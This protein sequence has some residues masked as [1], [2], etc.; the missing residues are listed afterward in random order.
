MEP[1]IEV[2]ALTKAFG[3]KQ[4]LRQ[5]DFTIQ[6][7]EIYGFLGPSGS[8]KTTTVKILSGQLL[9]TTGTARV[10][11]VDIAKMN[12]ADRH[13]HLSRIGILT[14][15]STL[16]DRLSIQDNLELFCKLY[17]VPS[18]RAK[19]VLEQ[20]NLANERQTTVKT[21]SKG[22]KQRV[23]LARALLHNPDI[24]FLDEPTSALDPTNT[25]HIHDALKALNRAGTTIFLTTHDMEEAESLCHQ[26]A[27]LHQ[28]HIAAMDTP[29]RL[30]LKYA[31]STITVTTAEGT[32]S[33]QRD[34]EGAR[35]IYDW[36]TTGKMV[37]IHSNEPTLSDIFIKVTGGILK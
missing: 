23:T 22:M 33:V 29:Q 4:A 1:I 18:S 24:L 5:I 19:E 31:D 26:V 25:R 16:Y 20:V 27:F 21:L 15:N 32:Y 7:G 12:E 14:D 13:R 28:G 8:G 6:R 35:R 9:P 34:D 17:N 37:A 3:N 10:F 2:Q 36:M 30:R 11:G